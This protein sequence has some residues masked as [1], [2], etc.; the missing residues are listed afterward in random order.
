MKGTSFFLVLHIVSLVVQDCGLSLELLG[1]D[2][3]LG[4]CLSIYMIC[5]GSS[6]PRL[7][8]L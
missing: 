2:P 7:M 4:R 1:T 3:L 6:W 8:E 5:T